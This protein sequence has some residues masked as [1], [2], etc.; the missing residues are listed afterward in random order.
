MKRDEGDTPYIGWVGG[1]E[2][3]IRR[4]PKAQRQMHMIRFERALFE[5]V[6]G[7]GR[8]SMQHEGDQPFRD[9]ITLLL[10]CLDKVDNG[11]TNAMADGPGC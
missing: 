6:W 3:L 5:I 7:S 11:S 4:R 9:L 10:E 1:K 8:P 2:C